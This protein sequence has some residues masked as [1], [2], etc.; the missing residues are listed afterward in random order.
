M[1]VDWRAGY[2]KCCQHNTQIHFNL[3]IKRNWMVNLREEWKPNSSNYVININRDKDR[4]KDRDKRGDK[5][6]EMIP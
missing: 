6:R 5:E 2:E 3:S 1:L 4:D